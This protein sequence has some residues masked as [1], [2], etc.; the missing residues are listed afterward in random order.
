M[1]TRRDQRAAMKVVSA[2]TNAIFRVCGENCDRQQSE[3]IYRKTKSFTQVRSMNCMKN[4][5]ELRLHRTASGE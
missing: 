4:R 3:G 5:I 2:R 1:I